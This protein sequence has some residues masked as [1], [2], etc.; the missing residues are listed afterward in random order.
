MQK[1]H[2]LLIQYKEKKIYH[3]SKAIK[4]RTTVAPMNFYHTI[5]GKAEKQTR[6]HNSDRKPQHA[7]R[8]KKMVSKEAKAHDQ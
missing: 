7:I 5:Q 8:D 2:K 6:K 4:L 3:K 1:T